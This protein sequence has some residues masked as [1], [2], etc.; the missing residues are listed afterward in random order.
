MWTNRD[1]NC[2]VDAIRPTDEAIEGK[3]IAVSDGMGV[4]LLPNRRLTAYHI[5][6]ITIIED[7]VETPVTETLLPSILK[8][9]K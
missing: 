7:K 6:M 4:I 1:Y 3:L 2:K 8:G 5:S 9:T